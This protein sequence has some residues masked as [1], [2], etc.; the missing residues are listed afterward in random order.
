MTPHLTAIVLTRGDS[1]YLRECLAAL[2]FCDA[3]LLFASGTTPD[4]AQRAADGQA[5]LVVRPF[6]DY[7]TQRNAALEAVR[8]TTDWV[9][10]IDD[11]EIVTPALAEAVRHALRQGDAYAG[12][13]MTRHNYIFGKLTR[14]AGWYPDY[15][16]R[17]LR[18][19]AARYDPTR[20]VHE[21]V[22][23]DGALGTLETPIVHHNY[24]TLAQF[25]AKQRHY[26]AYEANILYEQGIRPK[27]HNYVLQPLRHF[28]W[29]YLTLGGWRDGFHGL[30]LSA[31]MAWYEL[32]K[33][34][35]LGGLWRK[36]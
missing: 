2:A 36:R 30:R 21:L 31:L 12:W 1:P 32:Q 7:A 14:G 17:L 29:R 20:K 15:Q 23:L 19:G 18:V 6:D 13:R 27:P 11:D 33:Y 28:R 34:R 24:E 8:G 3:R 10:F 26:T 16:T 35:I 5:R 25:I 22:M 9:L 4:T